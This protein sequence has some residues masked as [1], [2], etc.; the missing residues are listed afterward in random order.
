[1]SRH[2]DIDDLGKR[3]AYWANQLSR[4]KSYPWVGTGLIGDL[5]TVA[6]LH[7]ADF[8][9]LYPLHVAAP[10]KP[11]PVVI[12]DPVEEEDEF[13]HFQPSPPDEDEFANWNAP[14]VEFDL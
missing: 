13:A 8:D 5:K 11:D 4:D 9:Q 14:A 3:L 2:P 7:G 6:K 12:S 1:M 10:P